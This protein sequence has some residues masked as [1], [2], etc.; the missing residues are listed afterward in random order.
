MA[1]TTTR[2]A[3]Q[4]DIPALAEIA[5]A[6]LFPGEM[7]ADMIAPFL[8]GAQD[9]RWWVAEDTGTIAGFA[10]AEAE[11]ITDRTW[12]LR[13]L[14][15]DPALHRA[16]TGRAL[17]ASAEA[18]LASADGR[19]LII[20]TS[21]SADQAPARAF[22]TALDYAHVATIPDFWAAGEDKV[23]YAKHL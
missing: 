14:G 16:G 19:L 21:S 17:M 11:P 4:A 5:E 1:S 23:T 20:D 2:A 12:N 10:F 9:V 18:D 13:A 8:G 3:L 15:V 6:T 22:Y 7:L